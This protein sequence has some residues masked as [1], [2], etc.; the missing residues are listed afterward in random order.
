[1]GLQEERGEDA[2]GQREAPLRSTPHLDALPFAPPT[3]TRNDERIEHQLQAN[4]HPDVSW[5]SMYE[6]STEAP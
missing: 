2:H 4:Q 3:S 5:T 6:H 1:M